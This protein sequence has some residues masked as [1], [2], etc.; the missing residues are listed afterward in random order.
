M[1]YDKPKAIHFI[2]CLHGKRLCDRD[3]IGLEY[4]WVAAHRVAE[5]VKDM[6]TMSL[7]DRLFV[8]QVCASLN[9]SW[10]QHGLTV[11]LDHSR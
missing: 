6:R 2:A 1:V 11:Q 10:S 7:D 3:P 4:R 9:T 8:T 5:Q